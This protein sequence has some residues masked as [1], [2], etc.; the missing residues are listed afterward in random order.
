MGRNDVLSVL[1]V[2]V[3]LIVISYHNN[4]SILQLITDYLELDYPA[5]IIYNPVVLKMLQK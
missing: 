3:S 5:D 2:S 4:W 1:Y